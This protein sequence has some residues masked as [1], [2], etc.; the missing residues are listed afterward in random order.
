M[1]KKPFASSADLAP[2]DEV[3][4]E[5]AEG[6]YTL[7]AEGDP[8]VGAI[9]ADPKRNLLSWQSPIARA[10]FGARAGDTIVLPRGNEVEIVS[11]A[12]GTSESARLDVLDQRG[13]RQ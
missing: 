13:P 5:L 9:E 11:V 7:T 10:M 8:N 1:A 3:F 4:V 12:Y 2:K 6:V